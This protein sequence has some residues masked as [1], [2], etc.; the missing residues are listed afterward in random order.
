MY[1]HH[2]EA[3]IARLHSGIQHV[4]VSPIAGDRDVLLVTITTDLDAMAAIEIRLAAARA[5]ITPRHMT[6]R[7]DFVHPPSA[8]G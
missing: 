7:Y 8:S 4:R 3:V 5:S 1:L 6:L 2:L